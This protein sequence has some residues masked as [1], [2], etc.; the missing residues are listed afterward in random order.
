MQNI[1][2]QVSI[3]INAADPSRLVPVHCERDI[4]ALVKESEVLTGKPGR[5]FVVAGAERLS[6]QV[7]LTALGLHTRRIDTD[8]TPMGAQLVRSSDVKDH[9]LGDALRCGQLFTFSVH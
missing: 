9:T 3:A 2:Y 7:E 8:G 6:Y 1:Q 4:E 5:R